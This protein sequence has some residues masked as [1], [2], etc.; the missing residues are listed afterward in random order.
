MSRTWRAIGLAVALMAGSLSACERKS[1]PPPKPAPQP[2]K[3]FVP[4]PAEKPE[5][6]FAAGL[7]ERHPDVVGFMQQFLETCLAGDYS[8]YRR[9]VA[10]RSDPE[11]RARFERILHSLHRLTV[12]SIEP[13]AL[14]EVPPPVYLI[15]SKAEFVPDEKTKR[16]R[17]GEPPPGSS[18]PLPTGEEAIQEVERLLGLEDQAGGPEQ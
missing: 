10:R 6:S 9:L 16:R 2:A 11:S 8:E 14:Q 17:S 15:I 3:D 4:L 7:A 13:I 5:Y 1:P 18:G 12:E